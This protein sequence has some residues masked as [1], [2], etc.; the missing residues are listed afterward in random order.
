MKK[1]LIYILS[2]MLLNFYTKIVLADSPRNPFEKHTSVITNNLYQYSVKELILV[3][4]I[5][6]TQKIWAIIVDPQ[7]I[8]YHLSKGDSLG[9]EKATITLITA[10][11]IYLQ[12]ASQS[13]PTILAIDNVE[14]YKSS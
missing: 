8:I 9:I 4:I 5:S 13:Q 7:H 1:Y 11:K 10:N 14:Q 12:I 6:N 2:I 3:G